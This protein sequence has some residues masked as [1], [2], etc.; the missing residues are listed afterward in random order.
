LYT[1]STFEN[2]E[3]GSKKEGRRE[4]GEGEKKEGSKEGRKGMKGKELKEGRNNP[5]E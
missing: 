3:N 4:G 5:W 2:F 1:A